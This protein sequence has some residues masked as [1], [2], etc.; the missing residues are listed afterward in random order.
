MYPVLEIQ[1][2]QGNLERLDID[3]IMTVRTQN[4]ATGEIYLAQDNATPDPSLNFFLYCPVEESTAI[5]RELEDWTF[6]IPV[7]LG[8]LTQET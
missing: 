6:W 3:H 7:R 8:N 5:H 1:P 4:C 2:L